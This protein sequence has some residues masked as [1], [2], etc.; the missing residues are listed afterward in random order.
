[1]EACRTRPL[2]GRANW[3]SLGHEVRL[4]PP[5]Y[6]KP[7][8]KR[9]KTDAADAEAICEA[10]S[11]PTMRFVPVKSV[12]QPG[13][14]VATP[15]A[16]SAGP[17]ADPAGEHDQ[18]AC[19]LQFPG[20]ISPRGSPRPSLRPPGGRRRAHEVPPRLLPKVI[21]ALA[22]QALE[23]QD[24]IRQLE[25]D[26]M[27]WYRSN[28]LARRIATVPGVGLLGATALAATITDPTQLG[29]P[30]VAHVD[31]ANASAK[32]SSGGKAAL[33]GSPR[34]ATSTCGLLIIGMT[35]LVQ[36][37]LHRPGHGRPGSPRCW[38]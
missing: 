2:I 15:D 26:L 5:A 13:G 4:K 12:E 11:R 29:R 30:T 20:S 36:R 3:L 25:R 35:S 10:V 16:R 1:M 9:G 37:N 27:A 14:A 24:R 38:P 21:G 6:V 33:G 17:P 32:H 7:Y 31:Q 8:V 18:G 34:W 19:W 28:E 22:E 23:G